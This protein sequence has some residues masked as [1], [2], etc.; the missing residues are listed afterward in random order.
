MPRWTK[1][2]WS[3]AGTR[4]NLTD[5]HSHL[6]PYARCIVPEVTAILW[7]IPGAASLAVHIVLEETGEP[8]E[9]HYLD[10]AGP[11][12]P[13]PADLLALNPEGRVPVLELRGQVLTESAAICLHVSDLHPEVGLAPP[14]GTPQ[15]A[16][17]LRRLVFLTNT[18]QET[19]LRF[20]YPHRYVDDPAAADAVARRAEAR[21]HELV[22]RLDG[23]VAGG[24]VC[25]GEG[26]SVADVYLFMLV[27]WCR[28]LTPPAWQRQ[29]LRAHWLRMLERPAVRRV[30][31]DEGLLGELPPAA[32]ATPVA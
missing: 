2:S 10:I 18:V 16:E 30:L 29:H 22:G 7:C 27:R 11:D 5:T 6:Q 21:L 32:D 15:R 24:F 19:T 3:V 31:E 17:L 14:V 12:A 28:R 26:P 23:D 25:G 20:F 1:A 8:Y 13:R 9:L 4:E